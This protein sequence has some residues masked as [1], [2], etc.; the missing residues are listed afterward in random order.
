MALSTWTAQKERTPTNACKRTRDSARNVSQ[1]VLRAVSCLRV[2]SPAPKDA[3]VLLDESRSDATPVTT[4]GARHGSG[5]KSACKINETRERGEDAAKRALPECGGMLQSTCDYQ[6]RQ[7]TYI[8]FFSSLPLLF[9]STPPRDTI[10]R[11]AD[12]LFSHLVFHLTVVLVRVCFLRAS[13]IAVCVAPSPYLQ[14]KVA[15]S[16]KEALA[17]LFSGS[18]NC[19]HATFALLA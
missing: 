12:S 14:Y 10:G 1:F 7:R 2:F 4:S 19:L 13:L 11:A 6:E 15:P 17:V 3:D 9:F 8:T 18:M 16:D 5:Q